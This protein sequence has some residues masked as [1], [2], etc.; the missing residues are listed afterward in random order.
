MKF[1]SDIEVQAGLRDGSDDIGT[2]GQ[3]LSSTGTITNWIDQAEVIAAGATRVLIA[4]KNTSGGTIAKGTPVYQTGNVGATDVIEVAA[5]DALISTGYLPAIGLLETDLINNAF[6]HVVITGELLNITTDPID[7]LTPTTGDTI[8]LKS[9]GGLTLT[10]PTGEGN[11]IQNLGLVGKVSSGNSGSLT[12]ASIMRQNDVPN[13]PTGKIWIGDGNTIV[14]DTVYVDEPN[15]RV[16]IGTTSPGSKLQV[17]GEIDANGG[18][19]YR[20]NGKPWA[21]ESASVLRLGD[22][23][24]EVF[25]TS[26][27]DENSVEVFKVKD[28]GVIINC[29]RTKATTYGSDASLIVGGDKSSPWGAGVVT[30][31]NNDPTSQ[32]GDSTGLIQFAIRDDQNTIAGYTSASIKGSI[33]FAAGTGSSGGGILD[34]LT[35][36][37]ALGG[38]PTTRMRIDRLGNVGIGTTSPSEKLD[39][40]GSVKAT[41]STDAYKGYIKQTI[42]S[43]ANEKADNADYNLVP[44]NTLTTVSSDQSYNRMVAAYDGRIKKVYIRNT[45]GTVT[46]DTVNFKKQINNTTAATIYSATVANAGSAGM[47]AF[48]NFADSDFTFNEG[49]TFGILY[50]TTDSG[51]GAKRMAGVAINVIV[52]YNIT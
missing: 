3:L 44:Y 49:D 37:G 34:F 22:W 45:T 40:N 7:G 33:D 10:K 50:Q 43:S 25:S 19:G 8:Y 46:A 6:G 51:G 24:G 23:D 2:A 35:S 14:S 11:A 28:E 18:D 32:A 36:A 52:E 41:A 38:S 31:L 21:A 26:I 39:V 9:G 42:T 48:Y 5:A 4:C 29:D 27:F 47:S 16:G 17:D 15:N 12:V 30:L 20:I 1:K 13:L